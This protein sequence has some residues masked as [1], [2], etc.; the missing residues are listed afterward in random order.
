MGWV[1]P[2]A[3]T[4]QGG[5]ATYFCCPL[6]TPID[7]GPLGSDLRPQGG[8]V[9]DGD[10]ANPCRSALGEPMRGVWLQGGGLRGISKGHHGH[11]HADSVWMA[12]VPPKEGAGGR[13]ADYRRASTANHD[14]MGKQRERHTHRAHMQ[15]N[16]PTP[17]RPTPSCACRE[18]EQ[19]A[20][21]QAGAGDGRDGHGGR[22]RRRRV[23]DCPSQR[24]SS[25][26]L[27][28]WA[29]LGAQMSDAW[30]I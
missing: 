16:A 26:R 4:M 14:I 12:V 19:E 3:A 22:R 27:H 28:R 9:S 30:V 29:L 25:R 10:N 7:A 24:G 23:D 8:C 1:V 18:R 6:P 20:A 17:Q 21:R 13:G 15:N 11:P 5:F 2:S